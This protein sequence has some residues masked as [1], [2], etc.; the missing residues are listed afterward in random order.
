MR[1]YPLIKD[2]NT[3]GSAEAGVFAVILCKNLLAGVL[4]GSLSGTGS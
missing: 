2:K 4:D 3:P 1:I